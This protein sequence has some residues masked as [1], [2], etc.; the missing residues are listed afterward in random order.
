MKKQQKVARKQ[1][2]DW[3]AATLSRLR[4][5]IEEAGGGDDVVEEVKWRKPS[6]PRACRC[7]HP[8]A[9]SSAPARPYKDKVKLTFMK[10]ASLAD[11]AKL[12][13]A[14]LD[15]NARRAIDFREGDTIDE[16]AFK[17]LI[18]AAVALNA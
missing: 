15:G 12:F 14:S 16:K 5:L 1:S 6:N 10:G 7:G 18:R 4:A 13:N 11:P 2:A 9:A 8:P 3:R 17:S